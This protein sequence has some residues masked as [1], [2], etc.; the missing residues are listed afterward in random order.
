VLA[1]LS[2]ACITSG[3]LMTLNLSEK[4]LNT[5]IGN[6]AITLSENFEI[7]VDNIDVQDDYIRV[8]TTV[9]KPGE[10][11]IAGFFD[12]N[13]EILDGMI[14]AEMVNI[15]F[16]S[17]EMRRESI[18]LIGDLIENDLN[19]YVQEGNGLVVFKEINY[20]RDG[21]QMRF[22]IP[23]APTATNY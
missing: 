3:K 22:R 10:S 11:E 5:I 6:P 4:N 1:I 8:N 9:N 21:I 18:D 19:R 7:K 12:L 14:V 2:F 17:R 16:S 20:V 15:D 23:I 13:L